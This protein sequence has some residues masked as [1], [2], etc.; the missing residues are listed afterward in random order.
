LTLHWQPLRQ[1]DKNYTFFSQVVDENTTR[2]AAVDYTPPEGTQN[3]TAGEPVDMPMTLS[4]STETP[5]GVYPLIVGI[6]TQDD[7]GEFDRLQVKTVDG[8][9][10]DDFV[11]LTAIRVQP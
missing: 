3:W 8:R 2:W 9:L 1:P 7:D 6:Y 4:L 10:T 11:R 5:A